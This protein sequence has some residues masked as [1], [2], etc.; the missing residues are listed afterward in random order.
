MLTSIKNIPVYFSSAPS[1]GIW[2]RIVVK[3][4]NRPPANSTS[5]MRYGMK[6]SYRRYCREFRFQ[7]YRFNAE[8]IY[9]LSVKICRKC[10]ALYI[11]CRHNVLHPLVIIVKNLLNLF[12]LQ[13]GVK[14]FLPVSARL[15]S[16]T[17][18]FAAHPVP[19]HPV[20]VA[21]LNN[22]L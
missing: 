16:G 2:F 19:A 5:E 17:M 20:N 4:N 14:S 9:P 15:A 6:I 1:A 11:F 21:V 3:Y 10:G 8:I 7:F 12:E 18:I 22:C 13:Q